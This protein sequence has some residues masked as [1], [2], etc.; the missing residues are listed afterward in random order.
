MSRAS[1]FAATQAAA[2]AQQVTA[3]QAEPPKLEGPKATFVVTDEGNLRVIP[4]S[5][6]EDMVA[7]PAAALAIADWINATFRD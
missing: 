4:K 5:S 3:N 2:A 7:P 1:D 6:T